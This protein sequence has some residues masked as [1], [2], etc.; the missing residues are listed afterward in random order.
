MQQ[1]LLLVLLQ[2]YIFIMQSPCHNASLFKLHCEFSPQKYSEYCSN[3]Y[4]A[5]AMDTNI[6][7]KNIDI[8]VMPRTRFSAL[9]WLMVRRR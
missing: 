6:A 8:A 5:S 7:N 1:L 4:I 3:I 2:C 9:P